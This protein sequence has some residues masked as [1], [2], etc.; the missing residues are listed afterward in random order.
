[1]LQTVQPCWYAA[2]CSAMLVCCKLF[3]HAAGMVQTVRSCWYAANCSAM[4]VCCK[5]FN[6]AWMLQ[7]VQP[8]WNAVNQLKI[9]HFADL[10]NIL[11]IFLIIL[12]HITYKINTQMLTKFYPGEPVQGEKLVGRN[13]T[14][15]KCN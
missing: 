3:S 5:L 4:L 12:H 11:L 7:T 14:K 10:P 13:V 6:H 1:M 8:C 2:N 9:E 15:A